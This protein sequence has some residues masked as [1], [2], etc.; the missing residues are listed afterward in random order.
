MESGSKG[1]VVDEA[2][3]LMSTVALSL[4]DRNEH[5]RTSFVDDQEGKDD[6]LGPRSEF[7][8][9]EGEAKRLEAVSIMCMLFDSIHSI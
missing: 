1:A 9:C 2:A 3:C 8:E 4:Y 7:L 6:H 5:M